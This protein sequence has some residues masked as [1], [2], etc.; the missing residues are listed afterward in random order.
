MLR[1]KNIFNF[2][3]CISFA[4]V[5]AL[6]GID[7]A[8]SAPEKPFVNSAE[9]LG[10]RDVKA[11]RSQWVDVNNDGWQDLVF[12]GFKSDKK[13]DQIRL[14]LNTEKNGK[15]F[16]EEATDKSGLLE[17]RD[18]KKEGRI[19]SLILAGD[20][21][22]D[23]NVD[24]FSGAYC[25]F[26]QRKVKNRRVETDKDG[27]PLMTEQDHGDRSEILLGDGK[28][29]FKLTKE[30]SDVSKF[31]RTTRAATFLDYDRDGCLDLFT[32]AWYKEYGVTLECYEDRL[33]KGDGKGGFTEVTKK[34][35]MSLEAEPG[36]RN[37]RRPT[38][39]CAAVD[40]NNDGWTDILTASYG[41]QWNL[42]WINKGD[43]TFVEKGEET[44]FDGDDDE[45]G[46]YPGFVRRNK[47]KPFR[48]NGN[49]FSIAPGDYDSDGD[50]DVFLAEIT[51]F[52]AGSSSD[53]SCLLENT[54]KEGGFTFKRHP[55]AM[56]REHKVKNW[57]QGDLHTAWFDFD[58]D[59]DLDLIL[60]SSDYPDEQRLRVFRQ[61]GP[62]KFVDATVEL[63]IDWR[64]AVGISVGDFDRDGD[65]DI[66]GGNS[67]TRLTKE[68]KAE[69]PLGMA[70]WENNAAK[71]NW[72]TVELRGKGAGHSNGLG[73]GA[74]VT[75][76]TGDKSQIR[77]ISGGW[78]H[79]GQQDQLWAHFG[80]GDAKKIDK[81]IVRW[82]DK[83]GTETVYEN[84]EANRHYRIIEGEKQPESCGP[85]EVIAD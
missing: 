60:A 80:V 44:K 20:V 75:C 33:F 56:P 45:S 70:V 30:Q 74:R 53:R 47:E 67:H 39:G 46:S 40:I 54:G 78:G 71:G 77:E 34:A 10:L 14:F 31:P 66:V 84:L 12:L 7:D 52:W 63:G 21:N 81:L 18:D 43:G 16:F 76:V 65:L 27:N 17:N 13:L 4:L 8:F 55:Q 49:T 37:S 48:S 79:V 42:C 29:G 58:H 11:P 73:I 36:K 28:G 22:N 68:Q 32:G 19:C 50:M 69:Q 61:D 83:N 57:N 72:I 15:R 64:S 35:G 2:S 85:G 23:G 3:L 51:H 5:F 25:N 26:Q 6:A 62:G 38:Y 9:A 1:S 41:R 24:F 82:P 59:G